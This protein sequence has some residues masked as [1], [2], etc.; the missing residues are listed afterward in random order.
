MFKLFS[1]FNKSSNESENNE[2][3][4]VARCAMLV[5]RLFQGWYWDLLF[6]N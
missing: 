2:I 1:T 6:K 4:I 5:T 3:I